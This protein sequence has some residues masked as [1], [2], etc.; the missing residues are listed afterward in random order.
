MVREVGDIVTPAR[1]AKEQLTRRELQIMDVLWRSGSSSVQSVQR[2]LGDYLAYTTVQTILNILQRKGRCTRTLVGR[3]YLYSPIQDRALVL[4][5]AVED[6][7]DRFFEGSVEELISN[8][9]QTRK[10]TPAKL[11]ELVNKFA[12]LEKQ[13][14]AD[15]R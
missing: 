8:L 5:N 1:T 12:G 10:I 9:I 15:H 7:L 3:A 6:L 11:V 14:N 4:G 13:S 2:S